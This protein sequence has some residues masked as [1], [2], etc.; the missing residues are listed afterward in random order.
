MIAT[1][2]VKVRPQQMDDKEYL[3]KFDNIVRFLEHGDQ[4]KLIA[5]LRGREIAHKELGENLLLRFAQD[6]KAYGKAEGPPVVQE[7]QVF[8]VFVPNTSDNSV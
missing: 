2:E 8:L 3:F 4:V 1:K 5:M 7:R 6:L